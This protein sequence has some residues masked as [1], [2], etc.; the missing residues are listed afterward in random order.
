MV[1][2]GITSSRLPERVRVARSDPSPLEACPNTIA[3][4]AAAAAAA[5]DAGVV[6]G[7]YVTLA[8][9]ETSA[10]IGDTTALVT[11]E[12]EPCPPV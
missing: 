10:A 3:T 5:A 6:P 11:T 12:P 7:S 8:P 1:T 4:S 9:A 2:A